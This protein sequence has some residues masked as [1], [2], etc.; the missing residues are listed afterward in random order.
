MPAECCD[1][2]A[3][4]QESDCVD[5]ATRNDKTTP[6]A[7]LE[8]TAIECCD[9]APPPPATGGAKDVD[10]DG[11]KDGDGDT[12]NVADDDDDAGSDAQS[13]DTEA[14]NSDSTMSLLIIVLSVVG[15]C[16][17]FVAVARWRFSRRNRKNQIRKKMQMQRGPTHTFERRGSSRRG[18]MSHR[19]S[20]SVSTRRASLSMHAFGDEDSDEFKDVDNY[21]AKRTAR[22]IQQEDEVSDDI[23]MQIKKR[24]EKR[25]AKRAKQKSNNSSASESEQTLDAETTS[26]EITDNDSDGGG[27]PFAPPDMPDA[28][29]DYRMSAMMPERDSDVRFSPSAMAPPVMPVGS[30]GCMGSVGAS[31]PSMPPRGAGDYSMSAQMQFAPPPKPSG[32]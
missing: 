16:C 23:A 1:E 32:F 4:C 12:T 31:P 8:C 10:G 7:V 5:G 28:T 25:N 9:A 3:S 21:A 29:N 11:S 14:A 6:C 20:I 19:G 18:S 30:M 17:I 2:H 26:M 22:E 24:K 13:S 15:G 27:V